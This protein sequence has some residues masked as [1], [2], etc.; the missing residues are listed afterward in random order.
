M[1]K[2]SR[3]RIGFVSGSVIILA[4]VGVLSQ[5]RS[6]ATVLR[7]N[8]QQAIH[9]MITPAPTSHPVSQNIE[10][11]SPDGALKFI[12]NRELMSNGGIH[13]RFRTFT[14]TGDSHLL[15]EGIL[16]VG[17][18]LSLPDNSWSPDNSY[19]FIMR[20]GLFDLTAFVFHADGTAFPDGQ[21]FIDMSVKFNDQLSALTL[22]NVTGW[23]GPG[24]LH[25][26]TFNADKTKGPSYW[27]EVYDQ[28]FIELA[29]R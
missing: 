3:N 15:Y 25:V 21:P 14:A 1:V 16:P 4:S 6:P 23:D 7:A 8:Y 24:L 2:F 10:V 26:F 29:T 11:D 19:V 17:E 28:A 12:E 9:Q 5:Q 27:F 18:E 13:Y 20:R 22:R